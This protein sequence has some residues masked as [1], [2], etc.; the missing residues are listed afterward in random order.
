MTRDSFALKNRRVSFANISIAL[1]AIGTV[2]GFVLGATR[3]VGSIADTRYVSR[4]TFAVYQS[5][6]ANR[7]ALDSLS[8]S[9]DMRELRAGVLRT[10]STTRCILAKLDQRPSPFCP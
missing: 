3:F 6:I 9:R 1:T 8:T 10:D 7:Y 2:A 5:G 4:D